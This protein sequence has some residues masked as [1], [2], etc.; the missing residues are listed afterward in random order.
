MVVDK[1]F[2]CREHEYQCSDK[3]DYQIL[4]RDFLFAVPALPFLGQVAKNR[5]EVES[6]QL[7]FAAGTIAIF[8]ECDRKPSWNTVDN[9]I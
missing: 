9:C 5:D 1:K 6:I 2:I 8:W 3:F 4:L 7:V